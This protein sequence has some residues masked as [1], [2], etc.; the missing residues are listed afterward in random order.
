MVESRKTGERSSW[1]PI[2]NT[3][4]LVQRQVAMKLC[5]WSLKEDELSA[6]ISRWVIKFFLDTCT[7]Y[8]TVL[9]GRRKASILE[10]LPG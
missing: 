4:R 1:K 6:A 8:L 3:A 7:N 2:V 9:D 5:G 10:P